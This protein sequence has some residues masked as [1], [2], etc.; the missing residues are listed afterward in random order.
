MTHPRQVAV[1][2]LAAMLTSCGGGPPRIQSTS[3]G[4]PAFS[5]VEHWIPV[6]GTD[7]V[8]KQ[9]CTLIMREEG[10]EAKHRKSADYSLRVD[11]ADIDYASYSHSKHARWGIGS[12]LAAFVCLPCLAFAFLKKKNHWL[13]LSTPDGPQLFKLDKRVYAQVLHVLESHGIEVER[14]AED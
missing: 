3:T 10:I 11:Y 9:D 5:G 13:A 8:N 1:V 6:P 4:A 14:L 2:L 12:G 7:D